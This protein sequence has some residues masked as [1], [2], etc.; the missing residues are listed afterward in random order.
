MSDAPASAAPLPDLKWAPVVAGFDQPTDVVT[1]EGDSRKFVTEKTGLVRVVK[2]GRVLRTPYLD[3]TSKVSTS[4]ERGLLSMVFHPNFAVR[5]QFWV[6]YTALNGD[7]VVAR[8]RAASATAATARPHLKQVLRI[9]HRR[10]DNHNG[11]QLAFGNDRMMYIST[12]DG[13]GSG[14][15]HDHARKKTSLKGK[16]LRINPKRECGNKRY[17]IPKSNPFVGKA[18]RNEIWLL[19]ARNPWRIHID[20]ATGRLW[21]ADV[22]QGARE[23]VTVVRPK[24]ARRNLGWPCREGDL[25][26]DPSRC[27]GGPRLAP[28]FVIPHDTGESITGGIVYRGGFHSSLKGAYIFGDFVNG[29]VWAYR[30]DA[31]LDLQSKTL[32]PSR[33]AG[34]TAFAQ[35]NAGRVLAL[36][37][38]GTLWRLKPTG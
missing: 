26:Y 30:Y 31:G 9:P 19:G 2:N 18:G 27:T 14:D 6:F 38:D 16:I 5:H 12:G 29:R 34:P 36:T 28:R 13:G 32:G 7:L 10:E 23:E 4:G 15:P 22:G 1:L 20:S 24:P 25:S 35:T 37:Y 8:G 21:V 11:G 33:Y 17:C 3:L